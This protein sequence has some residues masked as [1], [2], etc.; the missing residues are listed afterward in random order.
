MAVVT[1]REKIENAC[2]RI[3]KVLQEL[4]LEV[5]VRVD[6]VVIEDTDIT[7]CGDEVRQTL[8]NVYLQLEETSQTKWAC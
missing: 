1:K 3:A 6:Q 2:L 7:N 8:R 4:E 5:G